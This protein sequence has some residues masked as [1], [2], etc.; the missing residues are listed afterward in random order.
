MFINILKLQ[1]MT[2]TVT[3]CK[4]EDKNVYGIY[5]QQLLSEYKDSF[6]ENIST[7]KIHVRLNK[8]QI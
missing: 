3:I 6:N 4:T 5:F 8:R 7:L 1:C 2:S